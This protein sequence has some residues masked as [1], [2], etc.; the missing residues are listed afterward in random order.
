MARGKKAV[1]RFVLMLQDTKTE[2][3]GPMGRQYYSLAVGF[4]KKSDLF[5]P[6]PEEDGGN[7]LNR[8]IDHFFTTVAGFGPHKGGAKKNYTAVEVKDEIEDEVIGVEQVGEK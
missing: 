3:D 1:P 2:I 4:H 5:K 6:I 7:E 8:V